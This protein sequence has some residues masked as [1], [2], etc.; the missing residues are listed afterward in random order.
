[1]KLRDLK[2]LLVYVWDLCI[3]KP[4]FLYLQLLADRTN[5]ILY[6]A[7]NRVFTV[8]HMNYHIAIAFIC[9][10]V[11]LYDVNQNVTRIMLVRLVAYRYLFPF[12]SPFFLHLLITCVNLLLVGWNGL[13]QSGGKSFLILFLFSIP[14]W[15]VNGSILILFKIY[16]LKTGSVQCPQRAFSYAKTITDDRHTYPKQSLWTLGF[17]ALLYAFSFWDAEPIPFYFQG[18]CTFFI[19]YFIVLWLG[20]RKLN[21]FLN[22]V[23]HFASN[24]KSKDEHIDRKYF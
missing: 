10:W 20:C 18:C 3:H 2:I 13:E 11:S 12:S 1:M 23:V 6:K 9:S 19:R 14:L 24:W 17:D 8:N 21:S 4:L 7:N 16:F 15:L 5:F 22:V